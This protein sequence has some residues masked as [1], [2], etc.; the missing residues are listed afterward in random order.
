MKFIL[1]QY[2]YNT[3]VT[4]QFCLAKSYEYYE[5]HCRNKTA[6]NT[7][8]VVANPFLSKNS[9][10]MIRNASKDNYT[11]NTVEHSNI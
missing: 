4:A 10:Y 2:Q 9:N 6:N 11:N 7:M 5:E 1:Y 3:T 8:W